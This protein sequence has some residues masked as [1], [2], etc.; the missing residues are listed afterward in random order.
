MSDR[1]FYRLVLPVS[2]PSAALRAAAEAFTEAEWTDANLIELRRSQV[3]G[4]VNVDVEERTTGQ[5]RAYAEVVRERLAEHDQDVAFYVAEAPKYEWLGLRVDWAPELG[6]HEVDCDAEDDPLI[7]ASTFEAVL[8]AAPSP[9]A[10]IEVLRL[11]LGTAW[12]SRR[13]SES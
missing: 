7:A 1:T 5:S 9:A 11:M 2:L 12:L 8:Q 4:K 10:A 6:W 13:G 3:D